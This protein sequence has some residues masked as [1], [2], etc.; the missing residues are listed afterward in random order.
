MVHCATP[1]CEIS[2][3]L[4]FPYFF[5]ENL[6]I[7]SLEEQSMKYYP[8]DSSVKPKTAEKRNFTK[9]RSSSKGFRG[10]KANIRLIC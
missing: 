9:Q 2:G 7:F 1:L 8:G 4:N 10:F 5:K 6:E 3:A